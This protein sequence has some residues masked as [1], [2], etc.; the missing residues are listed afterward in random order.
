MEPP[1]FYLV[2]LLLRRSEIS[3]SA[4]GAADEMCLKEALAREFPRY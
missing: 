4:L 2:Y 3:H 1:V